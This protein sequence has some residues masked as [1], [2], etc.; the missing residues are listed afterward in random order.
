MKF[1]RNDW[2][3]PWDA[4][5][6]ISRMAARSDGS[7]LRPRASAW[8]R[9]CARVLTEERTVCLLLLPLGTTCVTLTMSLL[10]HARAAFISDT[11][12]LHTCRPSEIE[13]EPDPS[14]RDCILAEHVRTPTAPRALARTLRTHALRSGPHGSHGGTCG[15]WRP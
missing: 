3:G 5:D 10:E 8:H 6:A 13:D 15:T 9:R 12:N 11:F 1:A 2:I 14:K 7:P 4:G